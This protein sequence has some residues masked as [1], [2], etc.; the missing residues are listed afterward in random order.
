MYALDTLLVRPSA[1]GLCQ[2]LIGTGRFTLR[3]LMNGYKGFVMN[4]RLLLQVRRKQM[5]WLAIM[6]PLSFYQPT[7]IRQQRR[8]LK[9]LSWPMDTATSFHLSQRGETM[10]TVSAEMS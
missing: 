9:C 3:Q 7:P 2:L 8:V 5:L 4:D 10:F 6:K 1:S